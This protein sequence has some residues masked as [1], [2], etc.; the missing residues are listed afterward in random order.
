MQ[1]I[2]GAHR[3]GRAFHNDGAAP[4]LIGHLASGLLDVGQISRL[5]GSMAIA[6]GGGVDRQEHHVG[7]AD[8]AGHIGAEAQVATRH[9]AEHR[10]E[11]GLIHRQRPAPQIVPGIDALLIEIDD[12]DV[13]AG[14][15]IGHDRHGGAT[16][17]ARTDTADGLNHG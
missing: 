12:R 14:A 11:P 15:A 9:P 16:D 2:G 10:F 6:L 4:R 7:L 13:E 8:R 5:P 1:H 3:Q 17:I